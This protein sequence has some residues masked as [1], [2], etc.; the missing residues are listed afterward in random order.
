MTVAEWPNAQVCKTLYSWVRIPP[1]TPE[2]NM[3]KTSDGL[4]FENKSEGMWH[5]RV[6]PPAFKYKYLYT[7]EE[8]N[9][10]GW[11][12]IEPDKTYVR[13]SLS[14]IIDFIQSDSTFKGQITYVCEEFPS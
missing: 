1:V 12:E 9:T 11:F 7:E 3:Y 6:L 10:R 14:D 4:I 2:L 13:G 8:L 5:E